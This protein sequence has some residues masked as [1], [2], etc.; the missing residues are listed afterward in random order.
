MQ[1]T[2]T[3][4]NT[5]QHTATHYSLTHAT[6]CNTLQ[7]TATHYNTL[8]IDTCNATH[9]CLP[10]LKQCVVV[11]C[12]VLQCVAVCCSVLQCVAVC[13][14]V[15]QCVA[16]VN[17]FCLPCLKRIFQSAQ[18]RTLPQRHCVGG[19]TYKQHAYALTC[20]YTHG[21]FSTYCR[22]LLT[23]YRSYLN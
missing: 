11:C 5:L 22:S 1:H 10:C 7:H 19:G 23:Y 21:L 6:H 3:H 2:A 12:S 8:L 14:S 9:A 4:C 18:K 20:I 16:C 15:L 17:D 13:C